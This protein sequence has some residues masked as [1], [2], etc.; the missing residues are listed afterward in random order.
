MSLYCPKCETYDLSFTIG[1]QCI[2]CEE[3]LEY[4]IP[5]PRFP[6]QEIESRSLNPWR[7]RE[8]IPINTDSITLGEIRT[9]LVKC[10]IGGRDVLFKCEHYLPTGSYKDRGSATLIAWLRSMNIRKIVEDSSGNAGASL[11]AYAA[12]AKISL[13]VFCPASTSEQKKMQIRHYGAELITVEGPRIKSTEALLNHVKKTGVY[14][15]SHLWNPLFL[16]GIQTMAFELVEQLGWRTPKAVLCPVGSGSI[17]LGLFDGFQQLLREGVIHKIP[18]LIAIQ[19]SNVS[20]VFKAWHNKSDRIKKT[21]DYEPTIAEG[22]ALPCPIRD[23]RI[24]TALRKSK[25]TVIRVS[26]DEIKYGMR[27]LGTQGLYVEPTSAVIWQGI[28]EYWKQQT[29]TEAKT[30]EPVVAIVSGN[31]LK[32]P[33]GN[34]F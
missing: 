7:Y 3:A 8:A 20:P 27:A 29:K 9:P 14:Y 10:D 22:I 13:K 34:N 25:G 32:S 24:I 16:V 1:Y 31:G 4:D 15:A 5:T 11:A 28:I 23:R 19:A 26:E 18:K 2:N 30:D 12:R 6:R 17:L 21:D 33:I